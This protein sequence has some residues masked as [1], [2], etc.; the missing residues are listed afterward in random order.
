MSRISIR[1][2]PPLWWNAVRCAFGLTALI[3]LEAS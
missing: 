3:G 2:P 1:V